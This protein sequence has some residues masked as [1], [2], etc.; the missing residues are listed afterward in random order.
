M[1]FH[2]SCPNEVTKQSTN[3]IFTQ[4][5]NSNKK[6][7]MWEKMAAE[8]CR[9]VLTGLFSIIL[10]CSTTTKK[11]EFY[12]SGFCFHLDNPEALRL[13]TGKWSTTS[14]RVANRLCSNQKWKIKF[15]T[16]L[17]IDIVKTFFFS[18]VG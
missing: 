13:L 17:E 7:I 4:A 14:T 16:S 9:S 6:A 12:G 10:N 11:T 5:L 15:A 8:L 18:L 2:I 1:L 3:N